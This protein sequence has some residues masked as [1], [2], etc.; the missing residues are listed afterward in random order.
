MKYTAFEHISNIFRI[1]RFETYISD[2]IRNGFDSKWHLNIRFETIPKCSD[3]RHSLV[4]VDVQGE[5]ETTDSDNSIISL[6]T[7]NQM[8]FIIIICVLGC[9]IVASCFV[10]IRRI[11]RREKDKHGLELATMH[12]NS[13]ITITVKTNE[14]PGI[15]V[16][17]VPGSDMNIA[18]NICSDCGQSVSAG[19]LH[20]VNCV[21]QIQAHV[22]QV[23]GEDDE[24]DSESH[25]SM[26]DNMGNPGVTDDGSG[27]TRR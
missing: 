16:T 21:Q 25:D 19:A 14:T 22:G 4:S 17:G 2:S 15:C 18:P 26:Y 6:I 24:S 10:C 5:M 27:Q 13:T 7:S 1:V 23:H 12:S 3:R 8:V 11:M 20:C 9:V